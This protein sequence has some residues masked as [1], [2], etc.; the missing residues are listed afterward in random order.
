MGSVLTLISNAIDSVKKFNNTV[1]SIR[2]NIVDVRRCSKDIA[3][4]VYDLNSMSNEIKSAV[5][6]C[7]SELQ[8]K[9]CEQ[10]CS[11]LTSEDLENMH[12]LMFYKEFVTQVEK[13]QKLDG[14][15]PSGNMLCYLLEETVNEV[16]QH[17][18]IF[19]DDEG[20]FKL[21]VEIETFLEMSNHYEFDSLSTS[22]E[23]S[24]L[25]TF[26]EE[27]KYKD[28]FPS[29]EEMGDSGITW[30]SMEL[31]GKDQDTRKHYKHKSKQQEGKKSPLLKI[32]KWRKKNMIEQN[33]SGRCIKIFTALLKM[34]Q[35]LL[36]IL[37]D[38][39][40]RE[41][42]DESH[43]M[44]ASVIKKVL[45]GEHFFEM[46]HNTYT[47]RMA[48]INS[49]LERIIKKQDLYNI[50]LKVKINA[51]INFK[52]ALEILD[53]AAR[54]VDLA[55]QEVIDKTNN[56]KVVLMSDIRSFNLE[57]QHDSDERGHSSEIVPFKNTLSLLKETS[58]KAI[59]N[60]IETI[61][62]KSHFVDNIEVETLISIAGAF[63]DE[64]ELIM[65][66]THLLQHAFLKNNQE[67]LLFF[68]SMLDDKDTDSKRRIPLSDDSI[69]KML[70]QL[71][72]YPRLLSLLSDKQSDEIVTAKKVFSG[73]KKV[74]QAV[75]DDEN[76]KD[77]IVE[78]LI[79]EKRFLKSNVAKI[80]IPSD[81]ISNLFGEIVRK[82]IKTLPKD[83]SR[84]IDEEAI[85]I[86]GAEIS[87][88]SFFSN[89]DKDFILF[90]KDLV[91]VTQTGELDL[92]SIKDF[93]NIITK[94]IL[95]KLL[96]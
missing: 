83:I 31:L 62:K 75:F 3:S 34:Q 80:R 4:I 51:D 32:C 11:R 78:S 10:I 77:I 58:S 29:K 27:S 52:E 35:Q 26:L 5:R 76:L 7:S 40:R 43:S 79:N 50:N 54:K 20:R 68:L 18:K 96:N 30:I 17:R 86:G 6:E 14:E 88:L 64:A 42:F 49:Q 33:T 57:E 23:N 89:F 2:Q 53:D 92:E 59:E 47:P 24:T 1:S 70:S 28:S 60:N 72:K 81:V 61:L 90:V 74:T 73:V 87:N 93:Q 36:N 84:F 39:L 19:H 69:K 56:T 48:K 12:H 44:N 13:M 94:R 66:P 8:K 85:C 21:L 55:K 67:I 63:V 38:H 95:L 91:R 82:K 46:D 15:I 45:E 71:R 16:K 22:E 65:Q 9:L 25:I 37:S 41:A